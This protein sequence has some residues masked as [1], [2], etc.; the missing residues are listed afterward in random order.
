MENN[1]LICP[2]CQ[3]EL[4]HEKTTG[5]YC[6]PTIFI[7]CPLGS[8]TG[9][10]GT[11]ELWQE[12]IRTRKALEIAKTYLGYIKNNYHSWTPY[13]DEQMIAQASN[14]LAKIKELEDGNL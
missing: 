4:K 13:R 9:A 11:K 2:F 3:Q 6:C 10:F 12:L 14:C 7:D 8:G 5:I 1:K